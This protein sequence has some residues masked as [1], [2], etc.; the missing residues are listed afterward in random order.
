MEI[1]QGLITGILS[2]IVGLVIIIWPRLITFFI[3]GYL[4]LIGILAVIAA[5]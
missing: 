1:T 3:G 4:I 2:I 5:F